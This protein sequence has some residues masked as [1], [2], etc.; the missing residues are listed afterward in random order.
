MNRSAIAE[1]S[2]VEPRRFAALTAA[3]CQATTAVPNL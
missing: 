3:E 2:R 1:A